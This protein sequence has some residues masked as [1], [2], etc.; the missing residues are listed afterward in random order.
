MRP[1]ESVQME[2]VCFSRVC[3]P[4]LCVSWIGIG[5][6]AV[7]DTTDQH[8]MTSVLRRSALPVFSC[9]LLASG[10]AVSLILF[11]TLVSGMYLGKAKP[12]L[13]PKW[14]QRCLR[15]GTIGQVDGE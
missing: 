5:D 6:C 1:L 7:Q 10:S 8:L 15:E 4:L 11:L 9:L 3:D 2:G 14:S 12:W 13:M